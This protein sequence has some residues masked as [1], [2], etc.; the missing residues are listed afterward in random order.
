MKSTLKK[1]KLQM[2]KI[3]LKKLARTKFFALYLFCWFVF[4]E[5][6]WGAVFSSGLGS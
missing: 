6:I 3:Y 2:L 5:W 1:R 4:R